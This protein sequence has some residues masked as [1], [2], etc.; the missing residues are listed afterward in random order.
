MSERAEFKDNARVQQGNLLAGDTLLDEQRITAV[1][2]DC[3]HLWEAEI[4][5]NGEHHDHCIA[6]YDVICPK[7]TSKI[8][9]AK[10]ADTEC[11]C[12]LSKPKPLHRV[13]KPV[14]TKARH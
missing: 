3:E 6:N 8:N 7:C 13:G 14:R 2:P 11:K 10:V 5:I 12:H 9:L 4:E 1:C